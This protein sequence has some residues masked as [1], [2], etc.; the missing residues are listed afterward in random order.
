MNTIAVQ[1]G[2]N[3]EKSRQIQIIPDI[4]DNGALYIGNAVF[5]PDRERIATFIDGPNLYSTIRQFV[6][7]HADETDDGQNKPPSLDYKRLLYL[8][9]RLGISTQTSYYTPVYNE[10]G[11]QNIRPLIDWLDYNGFNVVTKTAKVF[12]SSEDRPVK[13]K[14]N[15]NCEIIVDVLNSVYSGNVEHVVL[16]SGDGDFRSMVEACQRKNVRVTVVS[17]MQTRPT[18]MIADELRRQ[19]TQFIELFSIFPLIQTQMTVDDSRVDFRPI[20]KNEAA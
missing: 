9:T 10:D 18:I 2:S 19:A 3:M 4:E 20:A 17:S 5:Y 1:T 15:M 6:K 8:L 12:E 7:S 14:N 16:F 11:F 13:V